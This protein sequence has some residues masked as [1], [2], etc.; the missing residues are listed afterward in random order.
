MNM[1]AVPFLPCRNNGIPSQTESHRSV[2]SLKLV[3][4][5]FRHRDVENHGP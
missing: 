2:A 1:P 4:S 5:I 3:L